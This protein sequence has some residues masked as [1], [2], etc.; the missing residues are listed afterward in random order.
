MFV[1]YSSS[2]LS[3]ST[4]KQSPCTF[5]CANNCN[6]SKQYCNND[7]LTGHTLQSSHSE[8]NSFSVNSYTKPQ[9]LPST[10]SSDDLDSSK[11]TVVHPTD[12]KNKASSS[13]DLISTKKP[14]HKNSD[15][16]SNTATTPP[17]IPE[18]SEIQA[19]ILAL[20]SLLQV[21]P[22]LKNNDVTTKSKLHLSEKIANR[23]SKW[24]E[25]EKLGARATLGP[26]LYSNICLNLKETHPGN[27]I[28]ISTVA[29]NV[30]CF[31]N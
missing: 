19:S 11:T 31:L 13:L 6:N 27:A 9:Q 8:P 23:N 2:V 5:A 29:V 16:S 12:E 14:S 25:D 24:E 7:Q 17:F 30:N 15:Q 1:G 28:I 22:N 18:N 26:V 21:N 20:E 3:Q 4:G 10:N